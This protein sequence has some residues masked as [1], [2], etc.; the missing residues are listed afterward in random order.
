MVALT[1]A[2]TVRQAED[3]L[4]PSDPAVVERLA[5]QRRAASKREKECKVGN[6]QQ[7]SPR[8]SVKSVAVNLKRPW[9]KTTTWKKSARSKLNEPPRHGSQHLNSGVSGMLLTKELPNP[10]G[11]V[12]DLHKQDASLTGKAERWKNAQDIPSADLNEMQRVLFMLNTAAETVSCES[13]NTAFL[14][15]KFKFPDASD[16]STFGGSSPGTDIW[17][18]SDSSDSEAEKFDGVNALDPMHVAMQSAQIASQI[19]RA[20]SSGWS[21]RRIDISHQHSPAPLIHESTGRRGV[22]VKAEPKMK[23][24]KPLLNLLAVR[25]PHSEPVQH[26]PPGGKHSATVDLTMSDSDGEE[27]M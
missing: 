6:A 17:S 13:D 24:P 15:A 9:K 7:N 19:N 16:A 21:W 27:P 5:A 3:R 26:R 22:A 20:S 8:G 1:C 12:Y 14:P 23:I 4:F 25:A 10:R 2:N 18:S 11:K